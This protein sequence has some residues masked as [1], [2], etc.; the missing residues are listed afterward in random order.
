[1]VKIKSLKE[2]NFE[3]SKIITTN[4]L[5]NL[6]PDSTIMVADSAVIVIFLI[7]WVY[8]K[9]FCEPTQKREKEITV[10]H[11]IAEWKLQL[12]ITIEL[13]IYYKKSY[14]QQLYIESQWTKMRKKVHFGRSMHCLHHRPNSPAPLTDDSSVNFH[15]VLFFIFCQIIAKN[16]EKHVMEI[17]GWV[18][19]NFPDIRKWTRWIRPK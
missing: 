10:V 2:C 18:I 16:E 4:I 12:R 13:F 9:L 19:R 17:Y 6:F 5:V 3:K 8:K 1:M 11:K 15:D 7:F 14:P